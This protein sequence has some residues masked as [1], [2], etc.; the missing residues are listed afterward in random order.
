MKKL[1]F[2]FATFI[3]LYTSLS[4]TNDEDKDRFTDYTINNVS[5]DLVLVWKDSSGKPL[6]NFANLKKLARQNGKQLV[7]AMNGGMYTQLRKPLG[8]YIEKGKRL[9]KLN[10]RTG[11]GN[12]Y[13]K[14]NGVFYITK[15]NTAHIVTT[16]KMSGIKVYQSKYATQSGPMLLI[17]GK[18]H[19]AFIKGSKNLNI[20][21]GVGI[22]SNGGVVFSISNQP[23]NF[24][25]FAIHFKNKGCKYALYLDGF[26]SKMYY[27]E[28]GLKKM[29]RD[30]FGVMI[31]VIK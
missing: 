20:R 26:V 22:L 15:N 31:A 2:I 13:M 16:K 29:G 27:L 18:V 11:R 12:F 3:V 8:L 19:K 7:F 24:Y 28:K 6:K 17:D 21:N 14:P 1:V 9:K 4:F 10:T 23:V 30:K 25:D 5:D